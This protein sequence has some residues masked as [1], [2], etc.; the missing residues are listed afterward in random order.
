MPKHYVY[1][2]RQ[3]GLSKKTPVKVGVAINVVRRL[4]TL[5]T[6]NPKEL[7]ISAEFGPMLKSTAHELEADW[8]RK[9]KKQRLRGEWFSGKIIKQ[10]TRSGT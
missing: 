5:Q 6:G 2:I 8:H 1:I 10:I 7:E 9:F 3:R 4:K